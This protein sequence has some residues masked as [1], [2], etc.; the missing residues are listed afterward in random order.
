MAVL[1]RL[2]EAYEEYAGKWHLEAAFGS[3]AHPS[4]D[5]FA[6]LDRAQAW[7]EEHVKK[8][9]TDYWVIGQDVLWPDERIRS[10]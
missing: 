1:V 4:V 6:D 2:T 5:I 7:I 8:L 10:V 3:V 9:P